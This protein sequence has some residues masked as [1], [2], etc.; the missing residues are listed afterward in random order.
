MIDDCSIA[1]T[2][3]TFKK[4]RQSTATPLMS[5]E[6]YTNPF[7]HLINCWA[8]VYF[9]SFNNFHC[10]TGLLPKVIQDGALSLLCTRASRITDNMAMLFNDFKHCSKLLR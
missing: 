10:V 6:S 5:T 7:H 4:C 2:L 1:Q 3:S 9:K 8:T